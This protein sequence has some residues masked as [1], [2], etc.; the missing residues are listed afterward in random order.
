[1]R[2]LLVL[3]LAVM[4]V[5]SFTQVA[6]AAKKMNIWHL[7]LFLNDVNI[8]LDRAI[9]E[10]GQ[11]NGYDMK[12]T[13]YNYNDGQQRYIAGI[14]TNTT[15]CVGE[16]WPATAPRY[17]GMG[18][19][20]PLDDLVAEMEEINGKL[21]GDVVKTVSAGGKIYGVPRY[22]SAGGWF[23]RNDVFQKYGLADPKTWDDAYAAAKVINDK[24]KA[25]GKELYGIGATFNRGGDGSGYIY[26]I[27]WDYGAQTTD[28]SGKQ[29][30]IDSP[31][32]LAG[33]KMAAK[34]YG[35]ND[36]TKKMDP[37]VRV[38]APGAEA[39]T[40]PSN[41]EAWFAGVLAQTHNGASIWY[42]ALKEK[43]PL[44]DS[45]KIIRWLD[46]PA[47]P[48][49]WWGGGSGW[50]WVIFNNCKYQDDAKKLIRHI[51]SG[52]SYKVQMYESAGMFAPPYEK[53]GDLLYWR[54]GPN[55]KAISANTAD[56]FWYGKP[57][58]PTPAAIE[59]FAGN[60]YTDMV[61]RVVSG[62]LTPEQALKE[63]TERVKQ[64]YRS[65]PTGF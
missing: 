3:A 33:L 62:G 45:T 57:G 56:P 26:N 47:S 36:K 50:S 29:V 19:L 38:Q 49:R 63:A 5:V 64:I 55:L 41:N 24:A 10:W 23:I 25:E 52:R 31:E 37:A 32:A 7:R 12:I 4:L 51:T 27:L 60:V 15:P 43:H 18:K 22:I 9:N 14:E 48:E 21:R 61:G 35:W 58:P 54:L 11:K 13:L 44:L 8:E 28:E 42:K 39:Y 6:T 46:G 16:I 20:I 53:M 65:V 30:M 34:F 1:M 17:V 2:K 40:D 59:V